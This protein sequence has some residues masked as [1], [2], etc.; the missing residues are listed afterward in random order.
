MRIFKK[1][2][3]KWCW[4]KGSSESRGCSGF[5][6]KAGSYSAA[7]ILIKPRQSQQCELDLI[8]TGEGH[9]DGRLCLLT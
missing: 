8:Q 1:K 4:G 9:S 7:V 2:K 5:T 6:E 3:K